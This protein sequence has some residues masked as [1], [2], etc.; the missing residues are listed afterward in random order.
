S[1][2]GFLTFPV[3]LYPHPKGCLL[4]INPRVRGFFV[5]A[6][7]LS[8]VACGYAFHLV[9]PFLLHSEFLNFFFTR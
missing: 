4:Y 9:I 2:S 7:L 1:A 6:K 8:V 3:R 5:S